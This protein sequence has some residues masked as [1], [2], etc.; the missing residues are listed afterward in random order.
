VP[1]WHYNVCVR[2]YR[3][4]WIWSLVAAAVLAALTYFALAARRDPYAFL[5][6]F[7]PKRV[8]VFPG[9]PF[10]GKTQQVRMLEFDARDAPAVLEAM[11]QELDPA[12]GFSASDRTSDHGPRDHTVWQ[13][14]NRHPASQVSGRADW[15]FYES[16]PDGTFEALY[17]IGLHHR[18]PEQDDSKPACFVLIAHNESWLEQQLDRI[19]G[20]LHPKSSH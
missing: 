15:A 17:R 2:V 9:A 12:H 14:T 18:G 16:D 8:E 19:S 20:W 7:H 11:R 6:R 3:R 10:A 1:K 4:I 5:E 13:F